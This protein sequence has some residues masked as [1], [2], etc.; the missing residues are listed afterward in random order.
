MPADRR[1]YTLLDHLCRACG[2]RVLQVAT[3]GGA[4]GGGNPIFMCADCEASSSAM[5]PDCICWCG[6]A[7]RGQPHRVTAFRCVAFSATA[8]WPELREQMA[9]CGS[10]D[11]TR[12]K[13]GIVTESGLGIARDRR[14]ARLE[15]TNA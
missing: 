4:T 13:V 15:K 10:V 3:G 5:S 12:A 1:T 8:D 11:D 14:K 9:L 6:Y 7:H 2:G